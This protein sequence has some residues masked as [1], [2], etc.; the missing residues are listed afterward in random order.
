MRSI[1]E[2]TVPSCVCNTSFSF[3]ALNFCRSLPHR[4]F[5]LPKT[6]VFVDPPN[7]PHN[8]PRSGGGFSPP[9]MGAF[10][11]QC[12]SPSSLVSLI[13]SCTV[14]PEHTSH[15]LSLALRHSGNL[16]NVALPF[17]LSP[18]KH[19]GLGKWTNAKHSRTYR[20][21]LC[22]QYFILIRSVELLPFSPAPNV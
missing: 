11:P 19:S 1:P 10:T 5:S 7:P 2:L 6:E 4:M 9:G 17:G 3:G 18:H 15:C 20:P 13:A 8:L 16:T 21:E 12:A 14:A 22:L